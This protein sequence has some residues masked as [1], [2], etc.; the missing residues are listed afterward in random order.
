ME[1][2]LKFSSFTGFA[3]GLRSA[4]PSRA[5][6]GCRWWLRNHCGHN[7]WTSCSSIL[8]AGTYLFFRR[9]RPGAA[10]VSSRVRDRFST[11]HPV[12][13]RCLAKPYEIDRCRIVLFHPGPGWRH[14][15]LPG[16]ARNRQR[17]GKESLR[18]FF[19]HWGG[20]GRTIDPMLRKNPLIS[21]HVAGSSPPGRC[22]APGG[23]Q[24]RDRQVG[25]EEQE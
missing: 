21:N 5:C 22:S 15:S 9:G 7:H 3:A 2:N 1:Q 18:R 10:D 14:R 12:N 4:P 8:S 25:A 19:L 20:P 24:R 13:A 23:P 6:A 16:L 11:D 17:P